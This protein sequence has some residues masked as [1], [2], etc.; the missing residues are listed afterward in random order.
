MNAIK[1]ARADIAQITYSIREELRTGEAD[2]GTL[3]TALICYGNTIDTFLAAL[4]T[5]DET[6]NACESEVVGEGSGASSSYDVRRAAS[7]RTRKR[8]DNQR[9]FSRLMATLKG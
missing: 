5:E 1:K 9:R 7:D 2:V 8:R 6:S 3:A 4:Q